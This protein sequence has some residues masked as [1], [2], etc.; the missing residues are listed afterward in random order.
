MASESNWTGFGDLS[1]NVIAADPYVVRIL[2]MCCRNWSSEIQG[3]HVPRNLN[4]FALE[5]EPLSHHT[6]GLPLPPHAPPSPSGEYPLAFSLGIPSDTP[7][8]PGVAQNH[9]YSLQTSHVLQPH[10][11]VRDCAPFLR[12]IHG[13]E[14]IRF[15]SFLQLPTTKQLG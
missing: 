4:F 15:H 8:T 14:T 9:F 11:N 5:D 12:L 2:T 13:V 1:T 10:T 3:L 6:F 7:P